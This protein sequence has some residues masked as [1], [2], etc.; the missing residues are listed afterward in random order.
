MK[1]LPKEL[2]ARVCKGLRALVGWEQGDLSD[3]AS[4]A[5]TT[6]RNVEH[7][8]RET[9]SGTILS[10]ETAFEKSGVSVEHDEANKEVLIRYKYD[11]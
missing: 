4:I 9:N 6:I 10:I 3:Q 7:A 11:N 8:K 2:M 5:V 1:T